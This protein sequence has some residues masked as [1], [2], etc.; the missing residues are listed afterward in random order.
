MTGRNLWW[1]NCDNQNTLVIN[2]RLRFILDE[3]MA[4]KREIEADCDRAL[5]SGC[6]LSTCAIQWRKDRW[7]EWV[8]HVDCNHISFLFLVLAEGHF[9]EMSSFPETRA[10]RYVGRDKARLF[11]RYN[12]RQLSR[13]YPK[14]Q[15]TCC[16]VGY[17]EILNWFCWSGSKGWFV[18]LQPDAVLERRKPARVT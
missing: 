8:N 1:T 14:V 15:F 9:T 6:L 10:E 17:C 2:K 13:I 11:L 4:R 3:E 12:R 7:I 18:Q 16:I 5:W